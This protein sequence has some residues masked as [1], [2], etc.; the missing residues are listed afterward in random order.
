M[1]WLSL[2]VA[3]GNIG[4]VGCGGS[5]MGTTGTAGSGGHAG[6]SGPAGAGGTTGAGG[7]G[8]QTVG[9]SGCP[10]FTPDDVWNAD[11]SGKAVDAT[12][13]SKMTTLIGNVNI[14]PD[15]GPGFGI[16]INVVPQSQP[17]VPIVFDTYA[18]ES[19][20]GP[21][22]FPGPASVRVEGTD[23][24]TSCDGD[25]H[26][27]VVQQGTCLAY[28]GYGCQ[29][30]SD[31]WH[32]ANG[33][34]W[35]LK[36]NSQ[37]QRPDGWTSADAAGL[38]IYAGLAR[39]EEVVAGEITHAIRFTLPCTSDARVP[40]ATHQAVPGGCSSRPPAPPM[41][42]RVRLKASYDISGF[43]PV[44]QT[45]L[46]AFKKH[47][48]ILADNGGSSSTFFFQSED[49]P[50]WPDAINDLKMVPASAFEAV[51]P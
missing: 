22:P 31:G 20:K 10:L 41:G 47:G 4:L 37:G 11:V 15:F 49:S 28:E 34:K 27:I 19:D 18:S 3:I 8:G 30:N 29:Y 26:V 2:C 14:H 45:F 42:L 1:R 12:N 50:S 33:A 6:T 9:S 40:P 16:P 38:S 51:V 39:Y 7:S 5:S 44:V 36:K 21:Y 17:A 25:C 32:C 24:P 43:D 46:R 48:L 13:T 23:D 35:D